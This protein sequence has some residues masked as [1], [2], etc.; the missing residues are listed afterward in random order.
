MA[1]LSELIAPSFYDAHRDIE[2]EKYTHFWFKGGRGSCKS[3]FISL[4]IILGVMKD[5]RANAIVIR[6]VQNSIRDSVLEQILWAI[7]ALEADELWEKKIVW[8]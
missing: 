8:Y 5:R 6:K 2:K 1:K 3:S 7:D 4:E